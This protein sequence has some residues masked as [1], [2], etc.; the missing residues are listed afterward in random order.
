VDGQSTE[1][2][3]C[4]LPVASESMYS[5][6]EFQPRKAEDFFGDDLDLSEM[7]F[8]SIPNNQYEPAPDNPIRAT[9]DACFECAND[10]DENGSFRHARTHQGSPG[11]SGPT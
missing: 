11:C 6:P 8:Y 2:I 10:W 7:P 4:V 5:A 1:G 9:L 3:Y